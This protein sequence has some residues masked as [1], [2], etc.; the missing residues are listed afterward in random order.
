[1]SNYRNWSV[2]DVL[3]ASNGSIS[4]FAITLHI[5]RRFSRAFASTAAL[6]QKCSVEYF[7]KKTSRE[8]RWIS[9]GEGGY[10]QHLN[11]IP[12]ALGCTAWQSDTP[13]TGNRV[14]RRLSGFSP[15]LA[16]SCDRSLVSLGDLLITPWIKKEKQK[17]KEKHIHILNGRT[18]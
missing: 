14:I 9:D 11:E 15:R 10:E 18:I 17:K 16:T 5:F 8:K 6:L 12:L 3:S 4:F 1:M 2:Y 13:P 7:G